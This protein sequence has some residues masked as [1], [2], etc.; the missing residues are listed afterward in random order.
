MFHSTHAALRALGIAATLA[1]LTSAADAL[2]DGGD[3]APGTA[4]TGPATRRRCSSPALER[5]WAHEG[6]WALPFWER[7][8]R[9]ERPR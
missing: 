3:P 1:A 4:Q 2:A 9:S 6:P 8:R 7:S 5:P